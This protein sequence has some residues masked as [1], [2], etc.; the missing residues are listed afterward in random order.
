[1]IKERR[2]SCDKSHPTVYHFK[3]KKRNFY[4]NWDE[5]LLSKHPLHNKLITE[6]RRTNN[7]V[8]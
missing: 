2:I 5:D 4:K 3:Q 1:M 6:E 7:I 8:K